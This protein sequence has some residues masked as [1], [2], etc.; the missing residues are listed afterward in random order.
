MPIL[1][2][3]AEEREKWAS[4]HEKAQKNKYQTR[5]RL[6]KAV[7]YVLLLVAVVVLAANYHS[8]VTGFHKLMALHL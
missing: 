1:R 3:I 4:R 7:R 6:W 8:I 2:D 5:K